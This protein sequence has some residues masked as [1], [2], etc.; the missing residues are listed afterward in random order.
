MS[1]R[2]DQPLDGSNSNDP[3]S[4]S[5]AYD[6]TEGGSPIASGASPTLSLGLG[7]HRITLTVDDGYGG[8]DSDEVVVTV[9]DTQA[10]TVNMS[11]EPTQLWPPN[12][13]MHL[14]ASGIS[15][16]DTCCDPTLAVEVSSNEPING[17]GDGDIDPDWE[18]VDNGD[19]TFDV[20]VRAERAGN[21][22]GR[23]YT[24]TATATDCANNVTV[25]VGT[26]N[27][28]HSKGKRKK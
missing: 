10:P 17:T 24:I 12:H 19:G 8:T 23:V 7:T 22:E 14:V 16:S 5:L 1:T 9:V 26:V 3:D 28:P 11:V 25:N 18:V 27:V 15:A 2:E 4:D 6:W 13:T 21:G 20:Y